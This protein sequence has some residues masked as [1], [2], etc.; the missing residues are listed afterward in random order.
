[1]SDQL[2]TRRKNTIKRI[3]ENIQSPGLIWAFSDPVDET[4][5]AEFITDFR[6]DMLKALIDISEGKSMSL[7]HN[8][9]PYHL[10]VFVAMDKPPCGIT[11]LYNLG[12]RPSWESPILSSEKYEVKFFLPNTDTV[13]FLTGPNGNFSVFTLWLEM[14]ILCAQKLESKSPGDIKVETKSTKEKDKFSD[15]FS[16]IF[17]GMGK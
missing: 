17:S 14:R 1:M 10:P 2:A 16:G 9:D 4:I 11:A 7:P 6:R 15:I 13:I 12:Y 3:C 8:T 5:G